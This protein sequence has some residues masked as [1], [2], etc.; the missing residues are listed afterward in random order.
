[1]LEIVFMNHLPKGEEFFPTVGEFEEE[2]L[3]SQEKLHPLKGT[4][5]DIREHEPV[6]LPAASVDFPEIGRFQILPGRRELVYP[7]QILQCGFFDLSNQ[8]I[9]SDMPHAPPFV[10]GFALSR[11]GEIG[12]SRRTGSGHKG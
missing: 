9:L 8:S 5:T 11:D 1:M 2:S 7:V 3:G 4:G 10:H 6:V 12:A